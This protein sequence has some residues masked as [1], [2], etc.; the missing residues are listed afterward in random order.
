MRQNVRVTAF[1][2]SELLRESQQTLRGI[3]HRLTPP[4]P[5]LPHRAPP[6][7]IMPHPYD[8]VNHGLIIAKLEAYAVGENSLTL[9]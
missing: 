8:C 6:Y 4:Y 7:L 3:I 9:F 2:V 1:T 5:T